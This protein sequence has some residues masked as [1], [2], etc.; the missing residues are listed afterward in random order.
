MQKIDQQS[1]KKYFDK[2]KKKL[3]RP[4]VYNYE[5]ENKIIKKINDLYI[6]FRSRYLRMSKDGEYVELSVTKGHKAIN[7]SL[8]RRHLRGYET[9]GV[10]SGEKS[11]KHITFDVDVTDKNLAKW[12]AYKLRSTLIELGFPYEQIYVS[13]SG[14]KGFHVSLFVDKLIS[15]KLIEMLYDVVLRESD[16]TDLD[17]GKVELRPL[18]TRGVKLELGINFKNKDSTTNRCWYCDW[19][20]E[21]KPI[22]NMEY[23]LEIQQIK[24]DDF[25]AIVDRIRDNGFFD[26]KKHN[27]DELSIHRENKEL[28]TTYIQ[29]KSFKENT[30]EE[31]T[32]EAIKDIE[33]NGIKIPKT[34]HNCLIKL[35]KFYKYHGLDPDDCKDNLIQWMGRQDKSMYETSWN[36][37]LKDIDEIVKYIYDKNISLTVK[38]ESIKIYYE[39]MVEII[40]LDKINLK[41]LAYSMLMHSKRY[42]NLDGTFYITYDQMMESAS[43]KGRTTISNLIDELEANGFIQIVSRNKFSSITNINQPNVYKININTVSDNVLKV[44]LKSNTYKDSFLDSTVHFFDD[45]YLKVNCSRRQYEMFRLYRHSLTG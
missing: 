11:T 31:Y 22:E 3:G 29:P 26:I 37:C 44:K 8:I 41:V 16:L 9:Y 40:K 14:N 25:L 4:K 7:D 33:I 21:L 32:F 43:I 6:T 17:F 36:D 19:Y 15:I 28:S 34:R 27:T 10:F 45:N 38:Q 23:I 2:P 12:T 20:N 35:A 5:L 24:Y 1:N 18:S 42:A 13:T 30:D 39:E